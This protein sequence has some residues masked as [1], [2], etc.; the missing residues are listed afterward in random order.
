MAT[1]DG[2]PAQYG[3]SLK[4]LRELMEVRGREGILRIQEFGG[5]QEICKK[6]YTS[7]NEG[8]IIF[9]RLSQHLNYTTLYYEN[10][11]KWIRS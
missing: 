11:F 10:R 1:I 2:R 7:P 3:I 5:I 9:E 8:I 4:N 6:L